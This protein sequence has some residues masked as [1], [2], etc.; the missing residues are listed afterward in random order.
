MKKHSLNAEEWLLIELLFLA[1][2]GHVNYLVTYFNECAKSSLP[3]ET[4][5]SLKDKKVFSKSYHVPGENED[6]DFEEVEFSTSFMKNYFKESFQLGQ[7]LFEAYPVFLQFGDRL[8]PAK[9]ITKSGFNDETDFFTKYGKKIKYNPEMHLKV[10]DILQWSIEN[11]LI[12]YGIC[13]YVASSKWN[14]HIKIR[15]SGEIGNFAVKVST[16][17]DV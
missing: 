16:M 7:E 2:E 17:V 1:Q 3:R 10:L 13:E 8:L 15:E 11:D 9:N 14:D 5:Q 6:F 12:T 4:L